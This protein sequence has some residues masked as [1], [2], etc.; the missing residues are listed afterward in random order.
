[1]FE[2][3]FS[4]SDIPSVGMLAF[5]EI[6][7]SADNAIVLGILSSRLPT[8]LR[9]KALFIGLISSWIFRLIAILGLSYLLTFLWIQLIGG[10]Y[11]LYLPARH[12]MKKWSNNSFTPAP[13]PNFW[14]TVL[15]I[16]MFDLAFAIDSIVAGVA[17]ISDGAQIIYSKIWIVYLGGMIGVFAIRFAAKGF[18]SL[19]HR[20]RRLE[21]AAYLMIAWI[22]LK[23]I[24]NAFSFRFPYFDLF[25]WAVLILLF[26]L[27]FTRRF[28]D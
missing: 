22:G 20:Y 2:Q 16:E 4:L 6:L 21:S 13:T 25:F 18:I 10:L 28:D 17:F 5:L 3:T 8:P 14:K 24:C 19:L 23:L 15:M 12:F 27:G 9:N 26:I 1:M 11:L 7:L